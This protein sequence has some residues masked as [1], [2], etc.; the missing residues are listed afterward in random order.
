MKKLIALVLV[1]L[2][3]LFY[4][5]ELLEEVYDLKDKISQSEIWNEF[6]DKINING[7]SDKEKKEKNQN[8]QLNNAENENLGESDIKNFE[9]I[10]LGENLNQVFSN[11][12]KPGR[13]DT[14]EY[15]FDWY[16]Y[17]QYGKEFAMV[18]VENNEVV[19]LYSNSMNSC[20]NQDIKINQDRQTVRTKITPLKYKRKG[21]TRYI[22]N[23][24]NQYD[25][26]NKEG[27]YITIFY[28]IH[29]KNRVC[30]YL[31]IDKT[32]EDE[33]KV[34]YPEDREELKKCFEL[35][36]IDLV[37][38]VRNQRSLNSLRYSE[39]ATLSSRKHSKDMRDNNFFDHINKNDETPF[40]RMKREGIVYTSAG[41]NIAA[42]QINAIYAHEAWMN[43]EGHRKNILGNYNNIGVGV[44]FGGSYK[45]YYTQNFYK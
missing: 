36:V 34:L 16:V 38:S 19:A 18:G 27:K 22:I 28:D 25:I 17:N 37:N 44:I 8:L 15:G 11:I 24:E 5:P 41:E 13:I 39:Q 3:V 32:T 7:N 23:S 10:T 21:N 43:S 33:F 30:S 9:K 29:E 2:I 42:G 31:I 4:S 1:V 45:T 35:E 40:D 26:I 12:G 14:S 6:L 20:E